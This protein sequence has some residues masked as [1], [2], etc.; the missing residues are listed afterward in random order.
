MAN[1]DP[2]PPKDIW[3][4]S[5][6]SGDVEHELASVGVSASVDLWRA[7]GKQRYEDKAVELARIIVDS[8]QRSRPNWTIPFAG[9][10][11]TGPGKDRILHYGHRGRE[12]APV[13]AL[14]QLCDAFPNNSD[15]M[16]W[17]AA[18]TLHS[19][20]LASDGKVHSALRDDACLH[21]QR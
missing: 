13:V 6:D 4:V 19:G 9:F 16:K 11:Y 14:T 3:Q 7:T 18:V 15:W 21:L 1:P 17:Y 2:G 5:F 12:Q 8:Q 20:V 10:F